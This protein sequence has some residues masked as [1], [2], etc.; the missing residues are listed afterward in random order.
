MCSNV[1][2]TYEC[3]ILKRIFGRRG[4]PNTSMEEITLQCLWD[5]PNRPVVMKRHRVSWRRCSTL[6]TSFSRFLSM[7]LLQDMTDMSLSKDI[8]ETS[9]LN[10]G[11]IS[12]WEDHRT[13]RKTTGTTIQWRDA[14]IHDFTVWDIDYSKAVAHWSVSQWW[15]WMNTV[16]RSNTVDLHQVPSRNDEDHHS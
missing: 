5:L 12:R 16:T 11:N 7:D 8:M 2:L 13:I 14:D 3:F 9:T 4:T 15:S 10:S 6:Q 1:K